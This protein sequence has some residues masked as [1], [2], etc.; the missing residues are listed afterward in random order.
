MTESRSSVVAD[1]DDD[2]DDSP[3]A[4]RSPERE[5]AVQ[6]GVAAKASDIPLSPAHTSNTDQ[7]AQTG[8]LTLGSLF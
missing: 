4:D 7:E 1:Q 8:N 6:V 5:R 3:E 2:E